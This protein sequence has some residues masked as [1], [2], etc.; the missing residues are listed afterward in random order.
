[1]QHG[2]SRAFVGHLPFDALGHQL[3]AGGVLLEIAIRRS[4]RHGTDGSHTAIGFEAAT[5]VEDNLAGGLVRTCDHAAHHGAGGT[6]RDGLGEI[7]RELDA[8]VGDNRNIACSARAI[9]DRSQLRHTH[10][11]HHASGADR[12]RSDTDLDRICPCVDQGACRLGCGHV[13]CD[14]LHFVRKGLGAG[15]RLQNAA[16]VTM[17]GVDHHDI[18]ASR[19]EFLCALE[20]RIPDRGGGSHTQPAQFILACSGVQHRLLRIL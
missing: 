20:P 17:R 15:D 5:L 7:A 2:A 19:D 14:H 6:C 18:H 10:A 9:H 3:V 13:A 12:P 11:G 1:M 8:P 4:T 16:R